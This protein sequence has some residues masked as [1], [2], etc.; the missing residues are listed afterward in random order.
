MLDLLG[1]NC[2]GMSL[3]V[4]ASMSLVLDEPRTA[5]QDAAVDSDMIFNDTDNILFNFIIIV[6]V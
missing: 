1:P 2:T 3:K 5:Q 6:F 4:V